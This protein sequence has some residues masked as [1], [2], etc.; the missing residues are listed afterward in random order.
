[1]C[2]LTSPKLL[3][4]LIVLGILITD[5]LMRL[6]SPIL[7]I[8]IMLLHVLALVLLG[9]RVLIQDLGLRTFAA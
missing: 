8:L 1:M 7:H 5:L 6:L 9:G 2:S 3:A 4:N